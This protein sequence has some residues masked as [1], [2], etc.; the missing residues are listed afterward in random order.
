MNVFSGIFLAEFSLLTWTLR[1]PAPRSAIRI[2]L[3]LFL[4]LTGLYLCSYPEE[5]AEWTSWSFFLLRTAETI[6]PSG[7]EIWRYWPAVGVILITF[8]II[9]SPPL[10]KLLSTRPLLWLGSISYPL[11]LIHGPLLHSLLSWMLFGFSDAYRSVV[12]ENGTFKELT[13]EIRRPMPEAWMYIIALPVFWYLLLTAANAWTLH[14]EPWCGRVTQRIE[15]RICGT[16]GKV[17]P[18]TMLDTAPR[19]NGVLA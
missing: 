18:V 8:G 16:Q 9:L 3:P 19:V 17:L 2:F 11:Y 15:E 13:S 14:V 10:Q 4:V 7:I 5:R 12:Q 6:A 1:F